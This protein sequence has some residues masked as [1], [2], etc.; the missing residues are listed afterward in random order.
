MPK[1]IRDTDPCP[2]PPSC[3]GRGMA[4]ELS[5]LDSALFRVGRVA[6]QVVQ[7]MGFDTDLTNIADVD[8]D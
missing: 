2:P 4:E 3:D 1:L 5:A 7:S 8:D 6:D